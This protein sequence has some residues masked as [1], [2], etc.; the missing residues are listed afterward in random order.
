MSAYEFED[1]GERKLVIYTNHEGRGVVLNQTRLKTLIAAFGPQ[2]DNW[3]GRE[4]AILRGTT[5][6]SGKHVPAIVIEP[7]VAERIA[8]R[9]VTPEP[10]IMPPSAPPHSKYDGPDD[11]EDD[12]TEEA[13]L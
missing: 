3:L 2:S 5:T 4:I 13:P 6:F 12:G 11:G 1:S 8:A 10:S 7:M 9:R